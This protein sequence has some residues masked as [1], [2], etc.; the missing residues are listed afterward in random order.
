[1]GALVIIIDAELSHFMTLQ[2]GSAMSRTLNLA[3]RLLAL[4]RTF[5]DLGRDRDAL[6]VLGQLSRFRELPAQ[7]A[8]ETQR[9]LGEIQ[10]RRGRFRRARRYLGTA[11]LYRPDSARYHY[12]MALALDTE[13][14]GEPERAIAHYRKSLELDPQQSECLAHLGVLLVHQGQTEEGLQALCRAVELAPSDAA[15]VR[16]LAEALREVATAEAA[17]RVL[18]A[19]LFRNSRDARFRK[20]WTDFQY[21]QLWQ[22]QQDRRTEK[23]ASEGGEASPVL[24]PFIRIQDDA[25]LAAKRVRRDP[26]APPAPPH[27]PRSVRHAF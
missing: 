9:R 12:L 20:L 4:G 17:R 15:P 18:L 16:R 23:A 21:Q 1:V 25:G 26:A 5:Q 10:L 13:E 3:D 27:L 8:E 22:Q 24:L 19:A 14:K 2:G 11:L 6:D 7:V